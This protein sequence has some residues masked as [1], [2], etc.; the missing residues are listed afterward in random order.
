MGC[1]HASHHDCCTHRT[2]TET[3]FSVLTN[4]YTLSRSPETTLAGCPLC[5]D[6][7]EPFG[8]H[9]VCCERNG[10]TQ[11]HTKYRDAFV[12]VCARHG[13]AVEKE[14]ECLVKRRPSD[15]LLLN[16]S[17]GQNVAIDFVCSHPAGVAHHLMVV[18]NTTKHCNRAKTQKVQADGPACDA[19]G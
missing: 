19:K 9:F 1:S 17:R 18:E 7:L 10:N 6:A 5:K 4:R 11:R 8:D 12:V 2:C 3:L 16:W 13:V 15:V 14:A